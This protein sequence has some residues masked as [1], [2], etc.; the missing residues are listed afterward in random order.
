MSLTILLRSSLLSC[1]LRAVIKS[2]PESY[3]VL[4]SFL[5]KTDRIVVSGGL[6][7]AIYPHCFVVSYCRLH[8]YFYASSCERLKLCGSSGKPITFF[9]EHLVHRNRN[10]CCS[11]FNH[12]RV[13][14]WF[15]SFGRTARRISIHCIQCMDGNC[16][17][18][19]INLISTC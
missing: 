5:Q 13:Q 7:K 16:S 3:M 2:E 12:F 10:V 19:T 17:F 1:G 9:S 15:F 8:S 6:L 14:C 11:N 4:L 18:E